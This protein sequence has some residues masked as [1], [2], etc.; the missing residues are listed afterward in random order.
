MKR[1]VLFGLG[2]PGKEFEHTRHNIGADSVQKWIAAMQEKGA[3]ISPLK[4]HEQFHAL[5]RDVSIDDAVVTIL[6]PLVF[7]N[8]S[9]KP[10]AA[11][12]RYNPTDTKNIFLVHD[13]LE[14]SLGELKFQQTGSAHGHNGVRSI[15]EYLGHMDIPRLRIGIGRPTDTMPIEKFVLATF[16]PEEKAV[17]KE[18]EGEIIEAISLR[19]RLI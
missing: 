12:L 14:L 6:T 2:N 8:E 10:L 18:K 7:M 1:F 11:Y 9:G 15:H 3:T 19:L 13:D 17:L 5:A 4:T 16:T